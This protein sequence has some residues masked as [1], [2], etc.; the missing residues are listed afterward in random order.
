MRARDF[1]RQSKGLPRA[2][3]VAAAEGQQTNIQVGRATAS[4]STL[5]GQHRPAVIIC[6]RKI[7][8]SDSG[9]DKFVERRSQSPEKG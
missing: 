1:Q 5:S 6:C 9:I 3:R 2:V 4:A 7:E 8:T